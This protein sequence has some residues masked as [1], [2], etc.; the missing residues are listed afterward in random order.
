MSSIGAAGDP[1]PT[2]HH[3]LRGFYTD[4]VIR[5]RSDS[6]TFADFFHTHADRLSD[7]YD[8]LTVRT[9]AHAGQ[10][11]TLQEMGVTIEAAIPL[12]RTDP[13]LVIAYAGLNGPH[14]Q[15]SSERL[16]A[17]SNQLGAIRTRNRK[18]T[19]HSLPADWSYGIVS[20]GASDHLVEGFVELY[21]P[22]DW[23]TEDTRAI[24]N[25]Q[26]NT[27]AYVQT[28]EGQLVSTATAETAQIDIRGLGMLQLVEITEASTLP[29]FQGRG[30]Y[31]I[32]SHV[33]AETLATDTSTNAQYSEGNLRKPGVLIAAHQNGREFN[34]F[35]RK[36][37]GPQ[38]GILPQN[39]HVND[40]SETR[41]YNDFAISY[42]PLDVQ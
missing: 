7:E 20:P 3:R 12:A 29:E 16:A 1:M 41:Q 10:L 23:R 32:A 30:L 27:I 28:D 34:H 33:L 11:A 19:A 35:D 38:F 36:D 25:D 4:G 37:L 9:I 17:Y 22:F 39:F 15:V 5:G 42:A 18:D 2:T 13:D 14:R 31:R 40:G 6:R 8:R 21:K 24:L 26:A